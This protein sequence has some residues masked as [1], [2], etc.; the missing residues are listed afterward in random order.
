MSD[1]L[2]TSWNGSLPGS[3]V[4]VISQARILER[5]PFSSPG[6]LLDPGIEPASSALVGRFFTSEP[7]TKPDSRYPYLSWWDSA[8]LTFSLMF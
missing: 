6:V 5:L 8:T 2:V 3:S 4:H 7:L 1:F